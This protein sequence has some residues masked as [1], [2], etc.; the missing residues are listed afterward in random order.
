MDKSIPPCARETLHWA[1]TLST[2]RDGLVEETG[3][4]GVQSKRESNTD[5]PDDELSPTGFRFPTSWKGNPRGAELP[6]STGTFFVP[7]LV[8]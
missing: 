2:S 1:T 7:L 3:A 6:A 5:A 8:D 4:A